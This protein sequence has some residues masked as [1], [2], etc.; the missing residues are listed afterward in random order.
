MFENGHNSLSVAMPCIY[1]S[2]CKIWV[3]ISSLQNLSTTS[4]IY[5][6]NNNEIQRLYK[7]TEND[8][9]SQDSLI[10]IMSRIREKG[11]NM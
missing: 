6:S 2:Q 1:H 10:K 11:T 9:I 7:I 4:A 3:L 8:N 5:L